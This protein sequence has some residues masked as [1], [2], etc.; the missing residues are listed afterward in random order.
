MKNWNLNDLYSGF[1]DRF[2]SDLT[3]LEVLVDQYM[4][5]VRTKPSDDISYIEGYLKIQEE[6]TT[7]GRT[8]SSYPSLVMSTDVTNQEAMKHMANIT[9]IFRKPTAEDVMFSRYLT[10]VDLTALSNKSPLIKQYKFGLELEQKE[11]KHLL[12]EKEEIL[13]AKMRELASGSWGRLQGLTTANLPVLFRG[14]E[15]TLSEVRNL[16][17][18]NDQSIR[19]D[20]YEAELKAYL[21]I[22]DQVSL[23]L[24]NIKREVV[25]MNELR[26]Y[27]SPIQKTL[28]Q[29][30]MTK[31]TLDAMISAMMDFRP[32][33]EKYLK[34]KAKY[35][36][37]LGGLPFYEMFAPVGKLEK[38][39]TYEEAQEVVK[40]GFYS[41]SKRLGDFA[42]KAFD[43]EWVDVYPK[44]GK[45]GGAFCSNQPQ[46]KQSR[47]MTNFTGSL[48]DVLTLAHELG[49]GY[50]GEVI[51][52]NQPLHWSYPMP[53][54]ETAS[55]FCETVVN[56]HL[57]S[58]LTNPQERLSVLENSLQGD[59]QVIIDILSRFIFETHLFENS[60]GPVSK[61]QM[62]DMMIEAQKEAYLNGLDHTLLHPYMWLNKGHYY[63]AGLNF[64]NFPY[65]FGLL[66]G[67]GLYAQYLKN[68]STFLKSYDDL[69]SLTT[70]T[71][72]EEV[73]KSMGIDVTKK[74]FW[75]ESL[76]EVKKDIDEVCSLFL[77]KS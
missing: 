41:Y 30:K 19:K 48:S 18:D 55:I 45:R 21:A 60:Q 63:S 32:H 66:F 4:L 54:A 14:K 29:S 76:S 12:T 8:L 25:L 23:A 13:Y 51:S 47:I 24:S 58:S 75:L 65:A 33:F 70:K 10:T 9:K 71:S 72:V 56:N 64:Y 59:T 73:A 26:G 44:K 37:Y 22:E 74:E 46:L 27:E 15:I 34:A 36:G 42:T 17:Y 3:K 2:L 57:L 49:H 35:L 50:H 1:D 39:Y 40:K 11:A 43:N 20:A 61:H 53:L 52:S 69:L 28:D 16:A 7:L 5:H 62:K 77:I 67:K 68:P 31:E 6:I 38:T